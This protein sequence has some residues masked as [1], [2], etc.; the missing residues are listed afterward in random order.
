MRVPSGR[1]QMSAVS[2][3]SSAGEASTTLA[4]G[5][6]GSVAI[7]LDSKEP[8]E[9]TD[10]GVVEAVEHVLPPAFTSFRL[11]FVRDGLVVPVSRDHEVELLGPGGNT[12]KDLTR[13]FA[14]AGGTLAVTDVQSMRE[15]L[16]RYMGQIAMLRVSAVDAAG[17]T[18]GNTVWFRV[19]EPH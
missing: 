2:Y 16:A 1:L 13:V 11:Q 12:E 18:H 7:V 6:S 19:G 9:E 15:V 3:P 8:A 4:P 10:L 5:A 17:V 14:I